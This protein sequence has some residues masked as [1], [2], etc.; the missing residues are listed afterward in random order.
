MQKQN[1]NIIAFGSFEIDLRRMELRDNGERIEIEPQ[2]FDLITYFAQHPGRVLNRDEIID[3]IWG[4]RIVSDAAISTKIKSARKALG[5]DG[6]RQDIIKTIPRKGFLFVPDA[7]LG[8]RAVEE[9]RKGQGFAAP[10]ATDE[11]GQRPSIVVLPFKNLSGD[12]EQSYF[13]DGIAEDVI[14]DLSRYSELKVIARQSAFAFHE[15][16]GTALDF[17][18]ELGV[19]YLVEGSVRRSANR[20]RISAQLVDVSS[21]ET[22]WAEKFDR[23]VED[24]LDVQEEAATVIVNILAGKVQQRHYRRVLGNG[25]RS[26]SAYD[27]ALKAQQ[28]M[29]RFSKI[30]MVLARQEAEKAVQLDPHL[31]RAHATLAW[32]CHVQATNGWHL[33]ID[34]AFERALSSSQAAV[35]ADANEPWGYNILGLSYWW[36]N[37]KPDFDRA[38][39]VIRRSISLNPSNAHFYAHLG[40]M[41]PYMGRGDEAI[42]ELDCAMQFNPLYPAM[43]L[44]HRSRAHFVE[45]RYEESLADAQRAAVELP[46]LAHVLALLA[47]GY[48]K[49]GRHD[50]AVQTVSELNRA[51]PDFSVGFVRRTVPYAQDAHRDELCDLLAKAGLVE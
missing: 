13:S 30:G 39:D 3:A 2:V 26:T 8:D 46:T 27:H 51:S 23:R 44:E 17:A 21:A 5:D 16:A 33:N 22:L 45:G 37:E 19:A 28:H 38:D 9:K 29:W 34:E 24:V 43:Y 47:V 6:A 10:K 31:A 4:G 1:A 18:M 32:A 15:R 40:A 7:P 35:E 48:E 25:E 11:G 42:K 50:Q 12:P 14:T 41:L 49:L 20:V 36:N